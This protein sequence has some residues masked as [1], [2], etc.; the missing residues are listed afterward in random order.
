MTRIEVKPLADY[1]LK[2]AEK[3]PQGLSGLKDAVSFA[4]FE[5]NIYASK[6]I[7]TKT[8]EKALTFAR[9]IP[10]VK[11]LNEDNFAGW[12]LHDREYLLYLP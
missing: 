6:G 8:F 11:D 12:M 9:T 2:V 3:I 1:L 4:A 10:Q 5:L 7:K